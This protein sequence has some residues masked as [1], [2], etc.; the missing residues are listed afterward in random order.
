MWLVI[1]AILSAGLAVSVTA[2]LD[3]ASD[4]RTSGQLEQ[5]ARVAQAQVNRA[6]ARQLDVSH[7]ATAELVETAEAVYGT[8]ARP[9]VSLATTSDG[10]D[11]AAAMVSDAGRCVVLHLPRFGTPQ[12]TV[13]GEVDVTAGRCRGSLLL[14]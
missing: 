2:F 7:F 11:A 4:H 13:R 3:R 14:P 8:E 6:R 10:L 1:V 12:V 9:T 5:V